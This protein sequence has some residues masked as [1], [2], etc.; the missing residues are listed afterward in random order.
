[1]KEEPGHIQG[2]KEVLQNQK[3]TNRDFPGGPVVKILPSSA[4][5]EGLSPGSGAKIPHALQPKKKQK[6]K[7]KT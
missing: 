6:Q 4:V 2:M 3:Q 7:N 1:M 5:G